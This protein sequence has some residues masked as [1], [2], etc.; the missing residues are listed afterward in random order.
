MGDEGKLESGSNMNPNA[1]FT[2]VY[3]VDDDIE[4]DLPFTIE[5]IM[6]FLGYSREDAERVMAAS[7]GESVGCCVAIE[8]E[9]HE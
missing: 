2:N 8:P 6:W 4:D 7:K 9:P 3:P 5:N 1:V